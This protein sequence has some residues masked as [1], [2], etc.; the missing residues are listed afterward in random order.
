MLG[1]GTGEVLLGCGEVVK[2]EIVGD[3]APRHSAAKAMTF[4]RDRLPL[5]QSLHT[6]MKTWKHARK[7]G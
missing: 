5:A 6:A 2:G 1:G 7:E 4:P 3:G